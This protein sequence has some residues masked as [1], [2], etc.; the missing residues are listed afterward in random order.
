[1]VQL[2]G[3]YLVSLFSQSK[4]LITRNFYPEEMSFVSLGS[5]LLLQ[6][7]Q[8]LVHHLLFWKM[9]VPCNT[10]TFVLRN[11]RCRES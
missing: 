9:K 8:S 1:M 4:Q 11:A 7:R 10:W 5:D 3:I 6:C 2:H